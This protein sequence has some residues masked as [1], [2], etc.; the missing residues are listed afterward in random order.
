MSS[1][2]IYVFSMLSLNRIVVSDL[3]VA[4]HFT[5]SLLGM[6]L[7]YLATPFFTLKVFLHEYVHVYLRTHIYYLQRVVG[8]RPVPPVQPHDI[9]L[10][11]PYSVT[12]R[13]ALGL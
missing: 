12:D 8:A 9:W 2:S 4:D 7:L 6:I 3:V 13:A 1:N 11:N 5:Y 10:L